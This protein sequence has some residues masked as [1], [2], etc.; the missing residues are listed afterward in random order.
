MKEYMVK[1]KQSAKVLGDLRT[2]INLAALEL[3][4]NHASNT[5]ANMVLDQRQAQDEE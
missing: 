5:I 1:L 4:Q 3:M 2:S